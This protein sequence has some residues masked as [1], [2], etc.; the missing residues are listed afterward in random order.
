[1]DAKQLVR[2]DV[3]TADYE[4]CSLLGCDAIWLL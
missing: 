4:K 1:M 2:F 3:F